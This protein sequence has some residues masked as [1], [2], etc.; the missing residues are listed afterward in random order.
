MDLVNNQ[1]YLYDKYVYEQ[2][3]KYGFNNIK[4][5][6]NYINDFIFHCSEK[7]YL[8]KGKYYRMSAIDVYRYEVRLQEIDLSGDLIL[9][10]SRKVNGLKLNIDKFEEIADIFFP[11]N[12]K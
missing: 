12:T 1:K 8:I 7:K 4:E 11:G 10:E 6:H 3:E 9:N 2:I 5:I